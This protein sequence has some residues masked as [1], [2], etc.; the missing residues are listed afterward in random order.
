MILLLGNPES[1]R[2]ALFQEALAR[3]GR[4]PAQVLP[5]LTLLTDPAAL[6]A[7]WAP[8]ALLRIES[9]GED[10]EVER[11]LLALGAAVEDAPGPARL[12]AQEALAL[13]YERGRIY[14]PR[15]WFLGFRRAL[16]QIAARWPGPVMS[17]PD[18]IAVMFDKRA[19]AARLE[20]AGVPVPRALDPVEGYD[21]LVARME[22]AGEARAFV[23]LNHG[24][25]ASGVVAYSR[26]GGVE[27]AYS[28]AELEWGPEGALRVYNSLQIRRYTR[29]RE[30]RALLDFVC[31]EG[32]RVERW[33]PKRRQG[34]HRLDLRVVV[35]DGRARQAVVRLGRSP[36]TNLHLGNGRGDLEAL[37][38]SLAPEA[39]ASALR[40]C[41]GAA[42]AFPRSL[43]CGVDLLL[44]PD[45]GGFAILEVNAFGDLLPGVLWEGM[46]TYEAALVAARQ[47]GW[48]DA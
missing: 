31:R 11:R 41:E 18:E 12:S 40:A 29:P 17:H 30:L 36:M 24:S 14:S 9:P 4:P 34:A 42:A 10:F 26:R 46:D 37:V 6:S 2:V 45:G 25:S 21:A 48:I 8:G 13:P 39:W 27:S 28:S 33:L 19:T 38:G 3:R 20:A 1:R 15:Q 23:K 7:R 35:I 47:R 5:W 16:E 22:A 44:G 43:C 32:A